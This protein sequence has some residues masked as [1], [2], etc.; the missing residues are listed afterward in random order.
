MD[1]QEVLTFKIMA[2][3][4]VP[5]RTTS[6]A[7]DRFASSVDLFLRTH[8]AE[9]LSLSPPCSFSPEEPTDVADALRWWADI[10]RC[11]GCGEGDVATVTTP[12]V[13][14]RGG[15]ISMQRKGDDAHGYIVVVGC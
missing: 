10:M 15:D 8:V 1:A 12:R 6:F 11:R 14:I 7:R 9:A 5:I 4:T 2:S 13:L 3:V